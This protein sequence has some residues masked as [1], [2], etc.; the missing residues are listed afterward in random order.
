M[1]TWPKLEIYPIIFKA[2]KGRPH[3]RNSRTTFMLPSTVLL[4]LEHIEKSSGL[5]KII[6]CCEAKNETNK[7]NVYILK[8]KLHQRNFIP[9]IFIWFGCLIGK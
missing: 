1:E 6:L 7:R 9:Y 5:I 3:F 2:Q 4:C 8:S